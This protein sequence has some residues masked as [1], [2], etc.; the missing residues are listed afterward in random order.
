MWSH[1]HNFCICSF[2]LWNTKT[3]YEHVTSNPNIVNAVILILQAI[4]H[5]IWNLPR[6]A[7][8]IIIHIFLSLFPA[9]QAPPPPPH[10]PLQPIAATSFRPSSSSS[11]YINARYGKRSNASFE[12]RWQINSKFS[13]PLQPH[14]PNPSA[15]PPSFPFFPS[16]PLPLVLRW[17]HLVTHQTT[18]A[19][20]HVPPI[21]ICLD[22]APPRRRDGW[23][24]SR[25]EVGIY[26]KKERKKETRKQELDQESD[27]E[28]KNST[29]KRQR[30]SDHFLSRV[31]VFFYKFPHLCCVM[32][33]CV[34][35]WSVSVYVYTFKVYH[36]LCTIL[37]TYIYICTQYT[38]YTYVIICKHMYMRMYIFVT[39]KQI[40]AYTNLICH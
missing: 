7:A 4:M 37:R 22:A 18:N 14:N 15:F 21:Y 10:H 40:S 30:K 13:P 5:Y 9:V 32:C 33:V 27:Q 2:A 3:I 1:F 25:P 8:F 26:K 24:E 17:K 19:F 34:C 36:S 23:K 28:N 12:M 31:L 20:Y 16:I 6:F 39:F 11:S 29:R 35:V 38:I